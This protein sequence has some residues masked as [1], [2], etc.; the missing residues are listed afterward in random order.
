MSYGLSNVSWPSLQ[1]I[2]AEITKR[3]CETLAG[4]VRVAWHVLEPNA[5]YSHNWHIEAICAHLEAVTDD[6]ITRLLIN[7]PPGSMK[8]LLVSVF[9]PAWEWGPKGRRSLRYIATSFNDKP[10]TRDSRKCRDLILSEWYQALWPDVKLTRVGETSFAN[11]DTG[12]REGVSFG[13]LTSQRGDRLILDDPHS[14]ETAESEVERASTTRKFREGAL[15]RLNDQAHSAIIVIMQ[16]LHEDDVSGVI[17]ALKMDYVHLMLPMEFEP[18]RRCATSIGFID[19]RSADG[20]LLD[21]LRWSQE[22]WDTFKR[23]TTA[24]AIAGQYQQRPAPR[25][26]A[27]FKR[28]WFETV[29]AAPAHV[30]WV[31]G[32][33]LAATKAKSV[34]TSTG[35]AFTA[36]VKLGVA[37]GVY[38][39]GHVVRER[40]SPNEVEAAI[41]NTASQD[42]AGGKLVR[43]S[44]PQDPG[45]SGVAQKAALAR[46][47]AGHDVHFSPESGEKKD[48]ALPFAAQ[49]E[50][51]NVKLIEGAWNE[52]YLDELC[53]FPAGKFKD[54]VDA[55]SRAFG[56]LIRAPDEV[57]FVVPFITGT[58][59]VIPG[60]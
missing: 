47:L 57:P 45:Q 42:D 12:S 38:Y 10:V 13:S 28:V 2:R 52:A 27:M 11:A 20:E 3:E 48:R 19:P 58:P 14:T 34:S 59:R 30:R 16:R 17:L 53:M 39:V 22:T 44:I 15:N 51:G 24:Y 46:L 41:K 6:R 33:D 55:S 37:N 56:E 29:K 36:G 60:Q 5:K 31:R 49:A 43:I 18:E 40:G 50:A 4:F 9:W 25:E 8:S 23:E 35:P 7:V 21:Q 32:W 54:Q 26:G 1:E